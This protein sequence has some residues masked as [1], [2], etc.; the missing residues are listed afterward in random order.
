[1]DRLLSWITR[2]NFLVGALTFLAMCAVIL[3]QVVARYVFNNALPWPEELGRY[4]FLVC[5]WASITLCVEKR[6]HL[7]VDMLQLFFPALQR[8]L[9]VVSVLS[10][11]VFFGISCVLVWQMT[12][13]VWKMGTHALTMPISMWTLWGCILLFCLFSLLLSLRQMLVVLTR[14]AASTPEA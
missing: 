1:M 3:L 12:M 10:T 4:L 5:A 14:R 9:N 8:S 2:L 6:E 7:R 13:R 11:T